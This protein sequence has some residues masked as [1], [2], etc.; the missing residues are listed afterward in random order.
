MK[1]IIAA[2]IIAAVGFGAGWQTNGWRMGVQVQALKADHEKTV[3][4]ASEERNRKLVRMVE[5]ESERTTALSAINDKALATIKEKTHENQALR[6]RVAA[7]TVG[8]RITA[9][10]PPVDPGP[11]QAGTGTSVDSGTTATL[12]GPAEQA[13]FALREG[14][15]YTLGQL[16]ACQGQLRLRAAP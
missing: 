16:G 10:C 4:D 13:Y 11:A 7:G 8:L 1:Y 2:L 14:I 6:A 9:T 15:T 3:A 5:R 12:D